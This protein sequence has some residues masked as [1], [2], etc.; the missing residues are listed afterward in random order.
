M[1]EWMS[2]PVALDLCRS[3]TTLLWGRCRASLNEVIL[4]LCYSASMSTIWFTVQMVFVVV[5][6]GS[7]WMRIPGHHVES[8]T[9]A[10]I[11]VFL[12]MLK[13]LG[14]GLFAVRCLNVVI[15]FL[16]HHSLF[17]TRLLIAQQLRI[18]YTDHCSYHIEISRCI[19]WTGLSSV[20]ISSEFASQIAFK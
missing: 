18:S 1:D 4:C 8:P 17:I 9:D 6:A 11:K 16:T 3:H 2:N 12:L 20:L 13:H 7:E 14:E 19:P 15:S 5:I 10:C